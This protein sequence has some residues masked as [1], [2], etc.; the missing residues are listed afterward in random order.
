M[1]L[2][3]IAQILVPYFACTSNTCVVHTNAKRLHHIVDPSIIT[4]NIDS[5]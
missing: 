4:S 3:Y 5:K 1:Y 2:H